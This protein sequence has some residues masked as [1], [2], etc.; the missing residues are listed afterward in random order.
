MRGFLFNTNL[1][2]YGSLQYT[3]AVQLALR[4][5]AMSL[6]YNNPTRFTVRFQALLTQH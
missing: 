1:S 2:C 3:N 6:T 5:I 4:Y